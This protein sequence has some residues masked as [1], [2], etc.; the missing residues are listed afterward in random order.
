MQ[1]AFP[2]GSWKSIFSSV[3]YLSIQKEPRFVYVCL[4]M[5]IQREIYE[6]DF[7]WLARPLCLNLFL[8]PLPFTQ[9]SRNPVAHRCLC[10]QLDCQVHSVICCIRSLWLQGTQSTQK[11]VSLDTCLCSGTVPTAQ[12]Y[13]QLFKLNTIEATFA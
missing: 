13:V 8:L 5:Y 9:N 6:T 11:L 10:V 3:T 12:T 1:S 2:V 4:H 7:F